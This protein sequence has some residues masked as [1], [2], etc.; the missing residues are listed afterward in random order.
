M[1]KAKSAR[2]MAQPL[3]KLLIVEPADFSLQALHQLKKHF[4]V[5]YGPKTRRELFEC[6]SDFEIFFVRLAHQFDEEFFKVATS[7]KY[8]VSPTT[9]LNHICMQSAQQRN[10]QILC[11]KEERAFLNRI[12]A[13]AELTWGLLLSLVRKISPAHQHVTEGDWNRD[14]F[15]GK[16]LSEL[17]LG[18]I[19]FGRLGTMVAR[20]GLA[21]GMEVIA[22]D[23]FQAIPPD[24]KS[25][26]LDQL[27]TSADVISVHVHSAPENIKMLGKKQFLAMKPGCILLNTSRGDLL[28]EQALL[29]SLQTGRLGGAGLDVLVDEYETGPAA[30]TSQ[31][32]KNYAYTHDNLIL[33]PHIGGATY[34]SMEKTELFLVDK[35][36]EHYTN[37]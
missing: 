16:E 13:T 32:L 25:V 31:E 15:R 34:E 10:I 22:H 7:L 35:L 3:P 5:S 30:L 28:D 27:C 14:Q 20:Y 1:K 17:T 12:T 8:L 11:L 23:P 29:D 4:N 26:S 21:F 36:L 19:G 18:I 2:R 9:G 24:I 6:A 33:T 37:A